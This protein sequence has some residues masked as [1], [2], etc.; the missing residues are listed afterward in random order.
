MKVKGNNVLKT[1]FASI[2]LMLVL[3]GCAEN[4]PSDAGS[5]ATSSPP[6]ANTAASETADAQYP[7]T[8]KHAFGETVIKS[9][10]ERVATIQ[11]ANQDVVLALGVVP[12]GFSAANYGVQDNSGLLPWTAKKLEELGAKKPNIFQ[13]TDGLDFEAIS[14][15]QPDVIL[16]AYSGITKE[17]YETLSKIAPV[18]A[19]PTQAWETSWRDQVLINSAGMGMKAEGEKLVKDT[20]NLIKEKAAGHPEL[21]GKKAALIYISPTDLSKIYVYTPEDPR[22]GFLNELGLSFSDSL[23]KLIKPDT[24]FSLE[25]SAEN[26][27]ALNDT[28][29]FVTYGDEKLLDILRADPLMSKLPAV[30]NGSFAMIGD[31][32]VLSAA[33]NPNPLSIPYT[34]DEYLKVIGEAAKKVQ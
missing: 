17:D 23:Q 27:E 7:I 20:E 32:S 30:K 29:I 5:S 34:I 16:A 9:K 12:V 25:L 31:G 15:A 19:Y 2:A 6:A 8:I 33:I 11:W 24:D 13:D 22:G 18:V 28:D 1:L 14:D 3:V 21:Q 4:K 10:P 26:I